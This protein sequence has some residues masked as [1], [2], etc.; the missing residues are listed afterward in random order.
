LRLPLECGVTVIAAH[1]ATRSGLGDPDYFGGFCAMLE[2]F[3]RLYGDTSALVSL[4][5][6]RHLTDCLRPGLAGRV[7]HGSD[8]P[9]PV[10]GHRLRWCGA[11]SRE[12]LRRCQAIPNVI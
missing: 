1:C 4:N 9:V 8:F 3:P 10:F 7:V 11:L 2:Q 6:C 12:E 5:R